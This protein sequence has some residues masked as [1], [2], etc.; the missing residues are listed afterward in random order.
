MHLYFIAENENGD[1][2]NL[3]IKI[4]ISKDI[5]KRLLHLQTGSPYEL[6]LMGWI[7]AQD[8]RALEK[9]LHAKY[10]DRCAHRE[11]FNLSSCDVLEEIKSHSI[12]GYISVHDN[13]FEIVSYDR[14]GVPEYLGAWQW[15]D[16]EFQEFCPKCGW[17]GG[18]DYNENYGGLR[19]LKCGVID[20]L[21]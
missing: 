2:D 14:D 11:W 5:K 21:L 8:V 20:E 16:V 3:R 4:G 10:R 12:N 19:C 13:A 15:T 7:E 1:Y 9:K 6:K 18:L 17:G